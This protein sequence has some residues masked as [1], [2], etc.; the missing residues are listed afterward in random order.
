MF[1]WRGYGGLPRRKSAPD[2][3]FEHLDR[4]FQERADRLAETEKAPRELLGACCSGTWGSEV[5]LGASTFSPPRCTGGGELS[6]VP[7]AG[8]FPQTQ[9]EATVSRV[10]SVYLSVFSRLRVERVPRKTLAHERDR[11]GRSRGQ[12]ALARRPIGTHRL[13]LPLVTTFEE[14]TGGRDGSKLG[15]G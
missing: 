4:D 14:T 9:G 10:V 1:G 15:E 7:P 2:L 6:P 5:L 8:G 13:A 12:L 3:R 11:L